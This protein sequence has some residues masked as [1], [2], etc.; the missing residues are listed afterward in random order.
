MKTAILMV[1][2]ALSGPPVDTMVQ[3]IQQQIAEKCAA[4]C[5]VVPHA[6][7]RRVERVVGELRQRVDALQDQA[8]EQRLRQHTRMLCT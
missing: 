4:G 1:A 5:Y 3:D 8:R 6:D 7:W 2:A